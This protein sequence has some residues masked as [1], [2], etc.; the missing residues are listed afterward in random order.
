MLSLSSMLSASSLSQSPQR[1]IA[2][3]IRAAPK[4]GSKQRCEVAPDGG[5]GGRG[6][7]PAGHGALRLL[8]NRESEIKPA[9]PASH[10]RRPFPLLRTS[11]WASL[12]DTPLLLAHGRVGGCLRE[13]RASFP[14]L[15][16]KNFAGSCPEVAEIEVVGIA[17]FSGR[18]SVLRLWPEETARYP[19]SIFQAGSP[20]LFR[21]VFRVG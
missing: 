8:H 13:E 17:L 14:R 5:R 1:G 15:R 10:G 21:V 19:A 12:P 6:R 4:P 9:S 11:P 18:A 3:R 16:Y 2:L 7:L 20:D